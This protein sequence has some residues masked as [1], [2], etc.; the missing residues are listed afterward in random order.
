[1]LYIILI[2]VGV[3]TSFWEERAWTEFRFYDTGITRDGN[4]ALLSSVQPIFRTDD[5]FIWDILTVQDVTYIAT[6]EDGRVYKIENGEGELFFDPPETNVLTLAENKGKIYIGTGSPGRV[7]RIDRE[8]RGEVILETEEEFIWDII[9]LPSGELIAGTGSSGL[10]LMVKEGHIDT[11]LVTGR[12]NASRLVLIEGDIYVGTGDGGLLFV[13]PDGGSPRGLYDHGEGEVSGIVKIDGTVYFS[14]ALDTTSLI[15]RIRDDGLV[16]N[17]IEI[18]GIARDLIKYN[19]RL[20]SASDRRIYRIYK[21]GKFDIPYE[22]PVSISAINRE[23]FIGLSELVSL[24]RLSE[25]PPDEGIVVS[26]SYDTGGASRWG[27]LAYKGRGRIKF[28]TRTGNTE[29]PDVTWEEWKGL[30]DGMI[31][32]SSN[33]FIRWRARLRGTDEIES[34]RVAYLP[35]NRRP[36]VENITL[37]PYAL[38]FSA[39]DPDKDNIVFNV[40]Y[41]EVGESWIALREEIADSMVE[42]EEDA[43]PDGLYQFKVEVS[44]AP[45]NPPRYALSCIRISDVYKI[46][47]TPPLIKIGVRGNKAMVEVSDNMSEIISFEYSKD[48][49]RFISIFPKDGIFD[50]KKENFE[51]AI[52]EGTR[53]L[54]VRTRDRAGNSSLKQWR[55]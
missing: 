20:L 46:D 6:G 49:Y 53:H 31:T 8:G 3:T 21:D 17:L 5:M 19:N 23:G 32:S 40:Y 16:E 38:T 24:Y 42:I 2:V 1:M 28:E 26:Y 44:D 7:Y 27:M 29:S 14:I 11:L 22:F 33:R 45:S 39:R 48:A 43:L 18:S 55:R 47:N 54:V 41:R 36:F 13:I 15:K 30:N 9:I 4:I 35:L 34:V 37:G 51:I 10:V 52:K 50:E 25:S 12:A